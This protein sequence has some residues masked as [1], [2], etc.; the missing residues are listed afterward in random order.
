LRNERK[1]SYKSACYYLEVIKKFY[2][3]NSEY[4]FKWKLIKMYLGDDD[5]NLDNYASIAEENRPYTKSEIQTMLKTATD[6]R[7]KIIILLISSAGVRMGAIP[8]LK[9][10]NLIKIEKYNLYQI[11]VYEN[12]KKSN[13]KTFCTPECTSVI[14]SYLQYR[15]HAG[16]ILKP[17][18][19]LIREQFNPLEEFKGS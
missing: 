15:K 10:R 6:S 18:S 1:I 19:P 14:D 5:D 11:N 16:E 13:Y 9:I 2:Y 4:E 17:E 12:S 8:L 3:V 7:V